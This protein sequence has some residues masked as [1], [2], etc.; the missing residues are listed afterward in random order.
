MLASAQT[1][2]QRV[3]GPL[4]EEYGI[5]MADAEAGVVEADHYE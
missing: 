5:S 4:L 3:T 2:L 1:V